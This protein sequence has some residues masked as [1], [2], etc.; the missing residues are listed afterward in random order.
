MSLHFCYIGGSVYK[1]NARLNKS[2]ANKVLLKRNIL[3]QSVSKCTVKKSLLNSCVLC[4]HAY[5]F[6]GTS[7]LIVEHYWS[8]IY[9]YTYIVTPCLVCV[10]PWAFFKAFSCS[11]WCRISMVPEVEHFHIVVQNS[12]LITF[13]LSFLAQLNKIW[14]VRKIVS[15]LFLSSSA[16]LGH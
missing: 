12:A 8:P 14:S 3:F 11:T 13:S 16:V 15:N 9:S 2:H 6:R 7:S 4:F 5:V 10:R 1:D